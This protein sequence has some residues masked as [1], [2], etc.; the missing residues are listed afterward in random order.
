GVDGAEALL[1]EVI[2]QAQKGGDGEEGEEG[3]ESE[4]EAGDDSDEELKGSDE[5][6]V[7]DDGGGKK[8]AS[9]LLVWRLPLTPLQSKRGGGYAGARCVLPLFPRGTVRQLHWHRKGDYLAT[10]STAGGA[11][12]GAGASRESV[13]VLQVS[14]NTSQHPFRRAPG[15]KLGGLSFHPSLP[16]LLVQTQQHVKIFHLLEQRLVKKLLSGCK[17]LSCMCIHPS[18]NHVLVGSYDRRVV[19]FD[20]D[21][22]CHPYKTLKFHSQ[23]VRSICVHERFP[24]FASCSDDG[25]V[26]VMHGMVYRQV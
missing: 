6:E 23:A 17:W 20:L 13:C 14:R 24:L 11:G 25:S 15:Q 3:E 16:L 22:S 10:L 26:H 19:W 2:A 8:K 1:Q 9:P 7:E 18:G 4:E 5:E 12:A 21:L